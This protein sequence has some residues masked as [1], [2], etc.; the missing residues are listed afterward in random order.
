[1]G[2]KYLFTSLTLGD[3]FS[4]NLDLGLAV[5]FHHLISIASHQFCNLVGESH[6]IRLSLVITT[7]LLELDFS[8]GHDSCSQFVAVPF[9]FIAEANDIK[10]IVSE[11]QLFIVIN[12][13][14]SNLALRDIAVV[15]SASFEDR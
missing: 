10:G 13:G 9:L 2:N 5:R 7:L 8:R 15:I 14:N 1:M 4:A 11:L 6:V 12:G 3:P